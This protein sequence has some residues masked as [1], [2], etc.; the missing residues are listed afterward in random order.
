MITRNGPIIIP[1]MRPFLYLFA[2]AIIPKRRKDDSG[3]GRANP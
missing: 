3:I 1:M 2:F